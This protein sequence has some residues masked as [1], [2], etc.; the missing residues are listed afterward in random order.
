[1]ENPVLS[2]AF[3]VALTGF[4]KSQFGLK[5]SDAILTAGLVTAVVAVFPVAVASFP[6]AAPWLEALFGAFILFVSANGVF[7]VAVDVKNHA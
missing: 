1:M 3:I 5:G 4:I 6:P 2:V 7:D